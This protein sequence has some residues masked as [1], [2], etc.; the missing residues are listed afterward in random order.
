ML[1]ISV[2]PDEVYT[3]PVVSL[4]RLRRPSF[5]APS[6]N[7]RQET[8]MAN[9]VLYGM[10]IT[11]SHSSSDSETPRNRVQ[12]PAVKSEEIPV[13]NRERA[14]IRNQ[15]HEQ[16]KICTITTR[17]TEQYL[18]SCSSPLKEKSLNQTP[19]TFPA[20]KPKHTSSVSGENRN[21][22]W[23]LVRSN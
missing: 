5:F 9:N 13:Y 19:N 14:S 2:I 7:T 20:L 8:V 15:K 1:L 16:A 12:S 18:R 21:R 11:T 10:D 6:S 17:R 4:T 3:I 22:R 23:H